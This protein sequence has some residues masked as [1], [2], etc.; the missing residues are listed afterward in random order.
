[1]IEFATPL[2]PIIAAKLFGGGG[3]ADVT[4]AAVAAAVHSMN[5]TQKAAVR[6]D[7][8]AEQKRLIVKVTA[9]A[10]SYAADKTFAQMWAAYSAD[11]AVAVAMGDGEFALAEADPSGMA[12][13]S[14]TIDGST[15]TLR[16]LA[17][18]D[19]N[20]WSY[21]EFA[22]EQKP[23][24]VTVSGTTPTITPAANTLYNCGELSSLTISNP[25]ALGAYSIVFTSG[26]TAT[27]TTIPAT[28]LGL[29]DFAAEA[30][31]VY[32]INVLDGRAVYNGW[33]LPTE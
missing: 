7:I 18:D 29:E 17:V 2:G 24:T 1:M 22:A 12:F 33:P 5:G 10:G 4:A 32:E 25:Q 20:T 30:N 19:N 3:S 11:R 13:V 9:S 27:T 16:R 26:A 14:T 31:T 15:A 8:D 23:T 28:I 21:T 6:S